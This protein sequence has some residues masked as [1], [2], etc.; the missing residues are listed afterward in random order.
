MPGQRNRVKASNAVARAD[1][2]S[3]SGDGI[4][5]DA[6]V[7]RGLELMQQS[8]PMPAGGIATV[9]NLSHSRFRHLFK[10]EMGM[11]VRQYQKLVRLERARDLL[12][13]SFLRVKEIA[14]VVGIGDMSHFTRDYKG[15]YKETPSQTRARF[16]QALTRVR[17]IAP[18]AKK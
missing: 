18:L 13:N 6:R 11:T 5:S 17:K 2:G 14:A 16:V 15:L 12:K 10:K 4:V 7:V 8:G 9:V 1:W 3:C